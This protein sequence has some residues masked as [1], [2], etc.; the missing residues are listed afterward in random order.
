[1]GYQPGTWKRGP[2]IA[3][4]ILKGD[5]EGRLQLCNGYAYVTIYSSVHF[6]FLAGGMT[7]L[8]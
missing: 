1:M 5:R 6:R 3:S 4:I 7:E 8:A 2:C